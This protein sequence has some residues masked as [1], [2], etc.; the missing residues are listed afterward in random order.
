MK[1][2]CGCLFSVIVSLLMCV[3]NTAA[4]EMICY[5]M[6]P[7]VFVSYDM[8]PYAFNASA[9]LPV[10]PVAPMVQRA[11]STGTCLPVLPVAP[12]VQR[13]TCTTGNCSKS[14]SVN[15]SRKYSTGLF[16]RARWRAR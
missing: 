3:D 1:I 4:D 13:G 12:I 16:G 14:S 8:E 11:C 9:P 2:L 10:L 5:N 15:T 6:S 7:I